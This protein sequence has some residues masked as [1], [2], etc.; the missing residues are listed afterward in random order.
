MLIGA[1]I[2]WQGAVFA[3][4]AGAAQGLV[5]AA[6]LLL[7]GRD[8][9]P[10]AVRER[11][12]EDAAATGAQDG[13]RG[14]DADAAAPERSGE[15]PWPGEAPRSGDA[16]RD[17]SQEAPE[18]DDARGDPVDDEPAPSGQGALRVPFGPFL[19][20]GALEFYFFGDA[21]LSAYVDLVGL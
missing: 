9:V 15:A 11:E 13:T 4:V 14:G 6:A 19:A 17:P 20:L 12:R 2:G 7:T 3:L 5:A 1:W 21:I 18:G 10:E 16:T 8:T